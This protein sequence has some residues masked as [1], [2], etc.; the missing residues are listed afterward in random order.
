MST[1]TLTKADVDGVA[2]WYADECK[3]ASENLTYAVKMFL[4]KTGRW[5]A[6]DKTAEALEIVEIACEKYRT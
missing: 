1:A 5:T 6:V 2:Q 4:N 3:E